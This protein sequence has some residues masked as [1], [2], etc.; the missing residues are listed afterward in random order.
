MHRRT[1]NTASCTFRDNHNW[2]I[3]GQDFAA[4]PIDEIRRL[5]PSLAEGHFG[6]RSITLLTRRDYLDHQ[7][8]RDQSV[9]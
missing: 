1:H 7:L 5:V 4:V 3:E 6:G 9:H 2:F 8:L